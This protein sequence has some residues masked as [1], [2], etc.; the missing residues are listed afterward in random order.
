M[1]ENCQHRRTPLH[2]LGGRAIIDDHDNSD[3]CRLSYKSRQ[4]PL[5]D[6]ISIFPSYPSQF[7]PSYFTIHEES[8]L[9]AK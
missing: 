8:A 4:A 1:A 2:D 7:V 3:G 9:K 5:H 6:N